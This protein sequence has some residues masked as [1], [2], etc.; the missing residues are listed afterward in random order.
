MAADPT[1]QFQIIDLF[2]GGKIVNTEIAFTNSAAYMVAAVV[3]ITAFLLLG[4]A[5]RSLV[6]GRIQS[7]AELTYEFV[8]NTIQS[9]AGTEGMRFF[10]FV[11]ALFTFILTVNIVGLI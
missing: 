5:G 6:P 11:F 4:T 10:P 7:A 2:S 3:I 1:H 8:A 9:T